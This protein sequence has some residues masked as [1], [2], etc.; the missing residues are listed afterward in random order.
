MLS[1]TSKDFFKKLMSTIS[2]SG[3]EEEAAA[4]WLEEA[5]KITK[6][7]KYDHFGN[8]HAVINKGGSPR[9]LLTGHFDEIGFAI[10]NIDDKGFLWIQ[11]IG[12]WDPQIPQ[13]H[14]VVIRG[15]KGYVKGVIGKI[16]VH[17]IPPEGR[18]KVTKI[19]QMW[20]DIGVTSKK[21]AEKLVSVGDPLVLDQD[22]LELQKDYFVSRAFDDKAGAFAVLEVA[23]LLAGRKIKPEVHV[24]ATAQEEVGLRGARTAA[25]GVDAEIGIATDVTHATDHPLVGDNVN[26]IGFIQIKEGAVLTRGP[27]IHPKL[28]ELMVDVATK[29]KI[30]HQIEVNTYPTG[31]DANAL[32]VNRAGMITGLVSIPNRYMHSPCELCHLDDIESAINLMAETVA[33]I[34]PQTDFSRLPQKKS[35]PAASARPIPQKQKIQTMAK[36][37]GSKKR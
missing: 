33:A 27:N 18:D 16:A 24:V 25:F 36:K 4:V 15:K 10:T 7:V 19:G 31:T 26:K 13:G 30:K 11:P 14:R 20:V 1:K 34:T 37:K 22:L 5:R 32:Q 21:E 12:G 2:P 8:A 9:V 28:F 6:H 3:Y 23:R 35:A 17:L 29:K